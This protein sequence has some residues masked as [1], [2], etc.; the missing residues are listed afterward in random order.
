MDRWPPTLP[1]TG[2]EIL[3]LMTMVGRRLDE[4]NARLER[5]EKRLD[6]MSDKLKA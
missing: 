2:N 6:E 4:I 1:V 3:E 5:I